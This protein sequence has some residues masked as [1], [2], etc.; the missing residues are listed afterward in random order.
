MDAAP[1][2]E[3]HFADVPHLASFEKEA[4]SQGLNFVK[5]LNF[6]NQATYKGYL[7]GKERHGP[8]VQVW[9]DGARYEGQWLDNKANGQGKFW[10]ADGDI[11][12]GQWRDDKANGH[13]IYTHTNGAKY[14]GQWLNDQ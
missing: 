9:P 1:S 2:E 10:H 11:Y 13:G 6:E 3:F 12:D 7:R 14:E 8:G 5:E 4:V